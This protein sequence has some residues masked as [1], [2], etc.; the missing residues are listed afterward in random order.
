MGSR[1][2]YPTLI[3]TLWS[4]GLTQEHD[5]TQ[6]CKKKANPGRVHIRLNSNMEVQRQAVRHR[7]SRGLR[8]FPLTHSGLLDVAWLSVQTKLSYTCAVSGCKMY[9]SVIWVKRNTFTRKKAPSAWQ[10]EV[11]MHPKKQLLLGLRT[12]RARNRKSKSTKQ[13]QTSWALRWKIR[14]LRI[15]W[16]QLGGQQRALS[17]FVSKL[18]LPEKK[19]DLSVLGK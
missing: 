5:M 18:R 15:S 14:V 12:N 10:K 3:S 4:I 11:K 9:T 6:D 2:T 1:L 16:M 17:S 8:L 13:E 19:G 7:P